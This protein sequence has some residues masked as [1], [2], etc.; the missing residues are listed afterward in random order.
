MLAFVKKNST[1][2]SRH[3]NGVSFSLYYAGGCVK[4]S[5]WWYARPAVSNR[6]HAQSRKIQFPPSTA[7]QSVSFNCSLFTFCLNWKTKSKPLFIYYVC[8]PKDRW[9]VAVLRT[10]A[11]C[12]VRAKQVGNRIRIWKT[13]NTEIKQTVM[14]VLLTDLNNINSSQSLQHL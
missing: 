2:R 4:E 10:A 6:L 13:S 5:F 8:K 3:S 9:S 1:S 14:I 11:I 12:M 7:T